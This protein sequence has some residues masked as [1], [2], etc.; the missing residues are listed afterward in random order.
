MNHG[1]FMFPTHDAIDP[2]SLARLAE[3]AGGWCP[4]PEPGFR[5]RIVELR[6]RASDAGREVSVS[7]LGLAP[8]R[9][10]LAEHEQAGA[11]RAVFAIRPGP[12]DDVQRQ[13]DAIL[14]AVG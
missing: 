7:V 2:A 1:L 8:D 9:E 12:R 6:A 11:D 10:A 13:L 3:E 4:L 5:E 14:A